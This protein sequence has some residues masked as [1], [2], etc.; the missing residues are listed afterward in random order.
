MRCRQRECE[1]ERDTIIQLRMRMPDAA[2]DSDP[3]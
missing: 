2:T 1:R 3:G